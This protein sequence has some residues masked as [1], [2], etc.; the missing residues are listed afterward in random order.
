MLRVELNFKFFSYS[1]N[2]KKMD[3]RHL[4]A[5]D[6]VELLIVGNVAHYKV[7]A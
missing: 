7:I 4:I 6:I 2:I 3:M 1:I 5:I